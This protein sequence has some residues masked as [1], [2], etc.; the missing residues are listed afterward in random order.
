MSKPK[1]S[2]TYHKDGSIWSKGQTLDGEMHGYWEFYRKGGGAIMRSGHFDKGEQAGE[3][4]T[5]DALGQVYK[6]TQLSPAKG[7]VTP[8]RAKSASKQ[9]ASGATNHKRETSH[10]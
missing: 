4:T 6:V 5:Y 7:G 2:R 8:K 10:G 1:P 9:Q 3:W